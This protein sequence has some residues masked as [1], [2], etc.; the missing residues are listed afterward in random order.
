MRGAG[1]FMSCDLKSESQV[2]RGT[3]STLT[4]WPS[5]LA[6]LA[7]ISLGVT[8]RGP[9]NSTTRDDGGGSGSTAAMLGV[10]FGALA[11]GAFAVAQPPRE[12]VGALQSSCRTIYF[13]WN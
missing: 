11:I 4:G 5:R 8:R 13:A 10:A 3:T 9:S 2:S 1:F 6:K 12:E 7:A